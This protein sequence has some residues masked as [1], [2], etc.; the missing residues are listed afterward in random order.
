MKKTAVITGAGRGI[1]FAIAVQLAKEGFQ[2]VL[3]A[4]SPAEKPWYWRPT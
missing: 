2:L 3:I 1:G 4:A